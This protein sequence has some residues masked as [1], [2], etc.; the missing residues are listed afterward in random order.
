MLT[1]TERRSTDLVVTSA[2]TPD[3]DAV[4]ARPPV[5]Y[6]PW[7][8][9]ALAWSAAVMVLGWV[10][11]GALISVS[12]LTAVH[13]GPAD[14]FATVGQA[15]LGLH[16]APA[17][18]GGATVRMVPLGLAGLVAAGCAASA[19]HAAQQYGPLSETPRGAA[20]A[21][22]SVVGACVAGYAAPGLLVAG[23]VGATAQ[24][25]AALPGL[26]LIPLAGASVGAL[27]GFGLRVPDRAPWWVRRLPAAAGAGLAVLALVAAVALGVALVVSWSD[28]IAIAQSLGPDAVGAVMLVLVHL[29]YLPT[30]LLWAGSFVLGAGLHLGAGAMIA[31]GVVEA[32]VLP[33]LPAF[34]AIPVASTAAD[35][36]WLAGGV[37]AGVVSG[38]WMMRGAPTESGEPDDAGSSL[39]T[40]APA[41][42]DAPAAGEP[43]ASTGSARA[44]PLLLVSGYG[45]LAGVASGLI[46]VLA[47]WL[48]VG[49][50]GVERLTGLGPRFPDLLWWGTGPLAAAGAVAALATSFWRARG[51]AE[52]ERD[53]VG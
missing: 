3:E 18:L 22:G 51:G 9:A 6:L 26:I 25:G 38:V 20:R 13:I 35:W 42:D 14:V 50:L 47:S 11:L 7:L 33:A 43:V 28:V 53:S 5:S 24:V 32:G 36:A 15:W 46:W 39:A 2:P 12:W 4:A 16:G 29:A 10:A 34:G 45:A 21:W 37:L 52:R 40:S 49:D 27:L 23:V 17:V 30:M 8:M 48:A 19:H 41:T 44:R 31:P 1:P